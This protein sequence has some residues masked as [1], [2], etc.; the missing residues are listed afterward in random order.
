M[1]RILLPEGNCIKTAQKELVKAD[2]EAGK[3]K[4]IETNLKIA[5]ITSKDVIQVV[6]T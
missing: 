6:F 2:I 1:S 4:S 3:A 5:V